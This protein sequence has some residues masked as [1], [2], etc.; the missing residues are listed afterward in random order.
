MNTK[1]EKNFE[2]WYFEDWHHYNKKRIAIQKL[3]YAV[4]RWATEFVPFNLMDGKAKI[5]LDVGCAHGYTVELLTHLGYD[6]YGCDI[7]RL[8]LCEY[9]RDIASSLVACDAHKLPF[10]EGS[11]NIIT[12]FEL[13]EHLSDQHE[14]LDSC[15]R[16]LKPKGILVLQ[17]PKAIPSV[18]G[19][20]S[21]LY[22][23]AVS[24]SSNVEHHISTLA[25]SSDLT[26]LLGRS[27]FTSHV[28][29]WGLL[30]LDPTIFDRYFPTRIPM[31]VPTFR[32]VAIKR[33]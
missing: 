16:C 27:G 32:A 1:R 13:L 10:H 17:T 26:S 7:S 5:A 33:S 18:D 23:K 8:Y 9:A 31:A 6:A 28:E 12:A 21:R 19:I 30:P 25:S 14:F 11:F 4:L 2:T 20:L 24:K 3:Y 15:F 22:A 29:T